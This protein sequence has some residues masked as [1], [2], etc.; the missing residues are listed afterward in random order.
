MRAGVRLIDNLVRASLGVY[1]FTNDPECILRIQLVRAPHTINIGSDRILKGEPVLGIHAWNEHIP[2]LPK[3]GANLEWAL[4]IRRR[5]LYSLKELAKVMQQD[6]RYSK[7]LA[8][9]G[10]S[11]LFSFTNHT[12]GVRMMQ[13][14]GFTVLPCD[15]SLGRFGE[16][17][18]NLFSWWLM[19]TY[20]EIS[21]HN[22][23]F[24]KLQRTEIWITTRDFL[25]RYGVSS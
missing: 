21:L 6:S 2:K 10:G 4:R 8:V 5:V 24:S 13:H 16:F 11:A 20:N 1:E 23:K 18:E 15:N 17:W 19:W 14:L 12:G 7:I 9:C 22:R 25:Q 3:E